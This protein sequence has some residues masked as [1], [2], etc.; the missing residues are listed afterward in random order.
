MSSVPYA[1]PLRQ[2]QYR[3]TSSVQRWVRR[4]LTNEILMKMAKCDLP[5]VWSL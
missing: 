3:R 5:K 2:V 1:P 4:T